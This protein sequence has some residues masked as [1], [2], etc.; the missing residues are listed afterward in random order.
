MIF[1]VKIGNAANELEQR[2]RPL[3]FE[4]V[5]EKDET[6]I[7]YEVKEESNEIVY[8]EL[9]FELVKYEDDICGDV[10][11]IILS[12]ESEN[13]FLL[14]KRGTYDGNDL[15]FDFDNYD[16]K[17]NKKADRISFNIK[18][19]KNANPCQL[20]Y[21]TFQGYSNSLQQFLIAVNFESNQYSI[22]QYWDLYNLDILD[23]VYETMEV[24]KVEQNDFYNRLQKSFSI[25]EERYNH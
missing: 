18:A 1:T 9:Y 14:S 6:Y 10:K 25:L 12:T 16:I 23:K 21:V 20:F 11:T 19:E 13:S 15:E 22:L 5:D 4:I 24:E 7:V 3:N 17:V 2:S 8:K